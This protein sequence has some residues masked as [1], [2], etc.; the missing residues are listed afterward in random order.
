MPFACV[1]LCAV[2]A[3]ANR[4]VVR[5]C[6]M[7]GEAGGDRGEDGDQEPRRGAVE[8]RGVAVASAQ[9]VGEPAARERGVEA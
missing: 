8:E 2:E 3:R 9:D 4:F 1:P 7:V 6:E 5:V